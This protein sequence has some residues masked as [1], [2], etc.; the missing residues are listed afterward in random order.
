MLTNKTIEKCEGNYSY[1][2]ET[3][4]RQTQKQKKRT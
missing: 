1:F 3:H 2:S 4:R